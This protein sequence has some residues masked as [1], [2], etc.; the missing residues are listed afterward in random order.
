MLQLAR[1]TMSLGCKLTVCVLLAFQKLMPRP[2]AVPESTMENGPV[3]C[4]HQG[5]LFAVGA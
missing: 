2:K 3:N 5:K 4:K 1:F